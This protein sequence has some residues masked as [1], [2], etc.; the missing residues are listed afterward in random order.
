MLVGFVTTEPPRE[1]QQ[2]FECIVLNIRVLDYVDILSF[3]EGD[4]DRKYKV[5]SS[6]KRRIGGCFER[7]SMDRV[8]CTLILKPVR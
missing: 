4:G 3:S 5:I 1:L 6:E 8:L 2:I 7:L